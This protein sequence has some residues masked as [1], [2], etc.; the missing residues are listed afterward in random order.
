MFRQELAQLSLFQGFDPGQLDHL[1]P[2]LKHV[3]HFHS[4]ET[5]FE[6]GKAAKSP[7]YPD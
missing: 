2:M 1:V 6:Q 3:Q 4:G 5:I 7:V